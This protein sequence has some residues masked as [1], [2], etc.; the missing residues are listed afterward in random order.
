MDRRQLEYFLS[1]ASHGSF[2]SAAHSLRV[3]QPS[4]SHAIRTLEHAVGAQLFHRLGR[5]VTLTSAGEA[6]LGPAQQIIR[7][8][9]TASSSVRA[10]SGLA[11]GHLDLVTLTTLAVDPLAGLVGA[12]RKRHPGVDIRITDPERASAVTEMVRTGRCELA[13]ADFSVA[14]EGLDSLEL[15]EQEVL[16][17]LPPGAVVDTGRPLKARDVASLD[18]IA[19]PDGTTTRAVLEQ[20][21]STAGVALRIAVE[22]SHR[23]AIVPMVLAGAGATLLPR[24]MAEDAGRQG[25]QVAALDPPI[26]R[27]VRLLWRPGPLSPAARAFVDLAPRG[28]GH[29]CPQPT[30]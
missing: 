20:A 8:F 12:F 4:L 23:A 14:E 30:S 28:T 22:T 3:A 15:P 13:L 25:A 24:P 18:L 9:H 19:T 7:D 1:V 16:A 2:T 17:V 5:G 26:V 11:A 6:L 21:L 10:V 29:C 27:R